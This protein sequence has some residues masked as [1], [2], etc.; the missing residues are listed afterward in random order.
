MRV[1][2]MHDTP[3]WYDLSLSRSNAPYG[4]NIHWTKAFDVLLYSGAYTLSFFMTFEEAVYW[5]GKFI[6]PLMHLITLF[7]IVFISKTLLKVDNTCL[8]SIL[9]PFQF[10]TM[11]YFSICTYDHHGLMLFL[12]TIY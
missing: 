7:L 10:V 2:K 11:R 6:N 3:N 4:E 1:E 8:L 12:F 5:F 9:F